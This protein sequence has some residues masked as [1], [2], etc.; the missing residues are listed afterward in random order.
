MS[1]G[2]ATT[3]SPR[4]CPMSRASEPMSGC[5]AAVPDRG[6]IDLFLEG[7]V[8]ARIPAS[9]FHDEVVL[10]HDRPPLALPSPRRPGGS[11]RTGQV[12]RRSGSIRRS[13]AHRH[14]RRGAHRIR[15]ALERGRCGAPLP[16]STHPQ[17]PRRPCG[18]RHRLVRRT[19]AGPA[20]RG[21]GKSV[22]RVR[23]GPGRMRQGP[24]RMRPG[25]G[26][27]LS[28]WSRV[29]V[30]HLKGSAISGSAISDSA[31]AH[32]APDPYPEK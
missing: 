17:A 10:D 6:V 13:P 22:D 18:P 11:E 24:G 16:P 26:S 32:R 21:D 14:P 4:S 27:R 7:I 5:E 15:F 28:G 2:S 8:S 20:D 23:P 1:S 9:V 19:L 25:L 31:G 3:R 29:T 30:D 12:V